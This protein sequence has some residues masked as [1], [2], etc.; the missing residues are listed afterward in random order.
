MGPRNDHI[1]GITAL[2]AL[3]ALSVVVAHALSTGAEIRGTPIEQVLTL[4]FGAIGVLIFFVISGYVIGLT[5]HSP[6]REF[7]I[8]RLVR[9]YPPFWI[10]CFIAFVGIKASG[11]DA[12]FYKSDWRMLSLIPTT[13]IN[14]SLGIPYWTLIYE[15]AFYTAACAVFSLKLSERT[16][17]LAALIWIG[18]ILLSLGY[19]AA[20]PLELVGAF[21]LLSPY[22]MFFA[23]GL[24]VCL[25]EQW[26]LRAN[27]GLLVIAVFLL[28]SLAEAISPLPPL[29]A[30]TPSSADLLLATAFGLIVHLMS[31]VRFVPRSVLA[32]GNSSYGLYLLHIPAMLVL[33]PLIRGTLLAEFYYLP[34][35]VMFAVP[36]AFGVA[37]GL[38]EFRMHAWLAARMRS[39]FVASGTPRPVTPPVMS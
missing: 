38:I 5:R 28:A 29:H 9:V 6:T 10:A 16:L 31:R 15:V 13:D 27:A 14:G 22:S 19:F 18:A 32:L 26:L 33:M 4:P 7:A 20:H 17:S 1:P 30:I 24:L 12:H 3:A 35:V 8:R 25:N 36:L 37:F 34:Y 21:L 23:V 2:R 39:V 11:G